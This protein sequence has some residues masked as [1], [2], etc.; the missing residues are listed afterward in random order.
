MR[1]EHPGA[2][3]AGLGGLVVTADEQRLLSGTAVA[4]QLEL[5]SL[6]L[7]P[8]CVGELQDGPFRSVVLYQADNAKVRVSLSQRQQVSGIGAAEAVHGLS[9]V[10]DAGQ[11]A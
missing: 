10:A 5:E 7:R 6:R 8:H 9:I 11:P 4:G 1:R 3:L 2:D